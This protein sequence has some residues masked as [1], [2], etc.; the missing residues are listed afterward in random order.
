MAASCQKE[1]FAV[2]EG[3]YAEV[4]FTASVPGVATKAIADGSS[5]TTLHYEVYTVGAD[6]Q[7]DQEV[8]DATTPV[9]APTTTVNVRLI[10]NKPYH[11]FFWAQAEKEGYTS[12][13]NVNDLRAVQVTY[14]N[15]SSNDELRDAFYAVVKNAK[16]AGTSTETVTL[17]RPFAQV[18]VATG[19]LAQL[20][21]E[22]VSLEN[23]TSTIKVTNVANEFHMF[24]NTATGDVTAEFTAAAIP[25]GNLANLKDENGNE[26]KYIAMAYILVPNSTEEG[27]VGTST[28]VATIESSIS[29]VTGADD[30]VTITYEGAT[31]QRNHRTNIVGK[32]LTTTTDYKAVVDNDFADV[33]PD[34]TYEY[35]EV[36]TP[37]MANDAFAAGKTSLT[38]SNV[39]E[40]ATLVLPKTTEETSVQLPEIEE[41]VTVTFEYPEDATEEEKPKVLNVTV[42]EGSESSFEFNLPNTT[43]YVNGKLNTVAATTADNTLVVTD[44]TEIEHL[45]VAKGNVVI[46]KGG[47]V[48][49]ISRAEG[50]SEPFTVELGE[51][52]AKPEIEGENITVKMFVTVI[53]PEEGEVEMTFTEQIASLNGYGMVKLTKDVVLENTLTIAAGQDVTIDLNGF[54][55]SGKTS[56]STN[57]QELFLVKGNL[58]VKNGTVTTEHVGENLG[59]NAMT[60]IFDVTAGGVLTIDNATVE[61]LGGTDM[62]FCVHLNNWGD[63]TLNAMNTSFKSSYVGIRAFNS[64]NDM[65][66]ITLN[67]CDLL[68]GNSCIW[69]HNYTAADFSNNA[70]KAAAAAKRLNF[71]FT[72][73][74]IARTNGSKSLVRFGF[75]DSIYYSS[76][77]MTE[78]VA[79][80][81]DALVYALENNKNVLFNSDLK[82]DPANMSNAYGKTGVNVKN[83]QTIDGNGYTL[84]IKGAGG[85]WD[86]GINTTGGLIKNIKVTGSFRGIFINHT[87]SHSETVVLENVTLDG[88]TYTISCDQGMNQNLEAYNSTF[89][90]WTSYAATIGNVSFTDCSFGQGNGYAFCRPYAPTT[91]KNCNFA[92]GYKVDP[93][94]ATTFENCT[95]NGVALTAENLSTLVTSNITNAT[96]K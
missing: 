67:N 53:E 41:G 39:G 19:D 81:A 44:G 79:G 15:Y 75:T 59:W 9:T 11:V 12:P 21:T 69:V 33:N 24:D 88:T 90:G 63:V 51:G 89:N 18:N 54:T 36:D 95:I 86:S 92:E 14:D 13:Y 29:N 87:S 8:Y 84:D 6:G 74:T 66:N 1:D 46:E 96:V 83:G 65:N 22:G 73:T 32:L 25:A 68:T 85:T 91:F 49:K 82:I 42:P 34:Y 80:T 57:P 2:A 78:V 3:D 76:L 56:G 58:T 94:A 35:E 43:V 5:V 45:V 16:Y 72:K 28:S 30:V 61:N 17:T 7:P 50:N 55:L 70:D 4:S 62:A 37:E 52:V 38:V 71:S 60:T 40:D 77:E 93:H 64:G 26:Y 23:A 47:K 10:K 27:L 48:T 20:T 31:I